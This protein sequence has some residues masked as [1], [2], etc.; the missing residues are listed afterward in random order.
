MFRM[1][2]LE[3]PPKNGVP[4]GVVTTRYSLDTYN[5]WV[6]NPKSSNYLRYQDNLY[7]DEGQEEEFVTISIHEGAY[8]TGVKQPKGI[9]DPASQHW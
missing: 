1:F 3:K 7:I 6:F 9:G 4:G 5:Q 2:F 8:E